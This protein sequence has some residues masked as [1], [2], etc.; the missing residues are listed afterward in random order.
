[1]SLKRK[2]PRANIRSSSQLS[3]HHYS[4]YSSPQILRIDPNLSYHDH[5]PSPLDSGV[6]KYNGHRNKSVFDDR[7]ITGILN[8]NTSVSP[9]IRTKL[10]SIINKSKSHNELF[11]PCKR[12]FVECLKF[13][14][15]GQNKFEGLCDICMVSPEFVGKSMKLER[16][17][18]IYERKRK[19]LLKTQ[20]DLKDLE[21]KIAKIHKEIIKANSMTAPIIRE[22]EEMEKRVTK[23]VEK[24]FKKLQAKFIK[25]NPF[26]DT[27]ELVKI[28]LAESEGI[29]E[30]LG[31]GTQNSFTTLQSLYLNESKILNETRVLINDIESRIQVNTMTDPLH[32]KDFNLLAYEF[33]RFFEKLEGNCRQFSQVVKVRT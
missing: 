28:K 1:M 19:D 31:E 24:C 21:V 16:L 15:V 11:L 7:S 26:K 13:V 22:L 9:K 29:L 3:P 14:D 30:K 6:N 5:I 4:P 12:H 17:V 8:H 23:E 10:P 2:E 27:R 32:E 25:F 33:E 18:D 20:E